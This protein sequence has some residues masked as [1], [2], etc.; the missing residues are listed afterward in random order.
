MA[1]ALETENRSWGLRTC[2]EKFQIG[3]GGVIAKG[4]KMLDRD[5][6]KKNQQRS[7]HMTQA[8]KS[9]KRI[10]TEQVGVGSG[11]SL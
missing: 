7:I 11:A 5:T 9:R 6:T 1:R 4:K 10:P 3:K 2:R 8:G